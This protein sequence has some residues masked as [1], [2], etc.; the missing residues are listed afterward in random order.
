MPYRKVSAIVRGYCGWFRRVPLKIARPLFCMFSSVIRLPI[1][2][3]ALVSF[4]HSLDVREDSPRKFLF[5]ESLGSPHLQKCG[6][7]ILVA[8]LGSKFPGAHGEEAVPYLTYNVAIP[9]GAGKPTV[10]IQDIADTLLQ[11]ELAAP[12]DCDAAAQPSRIRKAGSFSIRQGAVV[13]RDGIRR[14]A[15]DIPLLR[16]GKSGYVFRSHFRVS[17]QWSPSGLAKS[18]AAPGKRVLAQVDNPRGARSFYRAS[19]ARVLRRSSQELSDGIEWLL[20]I[21]VGDRELAT[22]REDGLYA[23]PYSQM[24]TRLRG[25]PLFDRIDGIRVGSLTVAAGTPDTLR[26]VPQT[27]VP[28]LGPLSE[29]AILVL[30]HGGAGD[31]KPDGI[32]NEGDTLVFFASGT[33]HWKPSGSA[34]MPY[35]FSSNLYSFTRDYY[36]GVRSDN[37]APR[38]AS[39]AQSGG[40]AVSQLT[41]YVRAEKDLLLRDTYFGLVAGGFDE[42]TGKEWFWIWGDTF[43]DSLKVGSSELSLP[44]VKELPGLVAGQ[45]ATLAIAYFPYRSMYASLAGQQ[46]RGTIISALPEY[47]R[48]ERLDF[49]FLVNG[50]STTRTT[51]RLPGGQFVA[52]TN[53]LKSTENQFELHMLPNRRQFDRFDGF[54]VAYKSYVQWFGSQETWLAGGLYGNIRF[55]VKQSPSNLWALRLNGQVPLRL[56]KAESGSFSDSVSVIDDAR[57]HLFQWGN[58]FPLADSAVQPFYPAATGTIADVASLGGNYEYVI[59]CPREWASTAVRLKKFREG[60]DVS[61]SYRTAVVELE[62]IWMQYGSGYASPTAIRD[63]L[64]MARYQWKDLKY[65]LLVGDGHPDYRG[66]RQ[67]SGGLPVIPP[68]EKEDMGTDDYFAVL[69]SGEALLYGDYDLDLAVGRLPVNQLGEFEIYVG[70]V[71]EYE[72]L[73][74]QDL[75]PWRNTLLMAADDAMQKTLLD[76][77]PGHTLQTEAILRDLEDKSM[78]QGYQIDMQRLYLLN[79][80]A[81]MAHEKPNASQ[82]LIARMNQGALFTIY[83]GH[84]SS[85]DWADEGLLKPYMLQDVDN[86]GRYTILGSFACTVGRFDLATM[87]SLSEIFMRA[88]GKGAIASIGAMRESFPSYNQDLA[89]GMLRSAFLEQG[90]TLGNALWSGKGKSFRTSTDYRYNNERYVLLGE[91]VLGLPKTSAD[92][93]LDTPLDTLQALQ[94]V[95][96]SGRVLDGASSGKL[97]I[98]VL[99]GPVNRILE[100][101]RPDTS[102]FTAPVRFQGRSI[103][104]EIVDYKEGKFSVEFLSPRKLSFGDTAAQIR[105]WAWSQGDSRIGRGVQKKVLISGTSPDAGSIVDTVPPDIHFRPCGIPDSLGRDYTAGVTV[106]MEIPACLEVMVDDSIG[107]DLQEQADEGISFEIVGSKD[108]WHPWPF[109]EQT[110]KRVMT[111]VRFNSSWNPGTYPLRVRAQDIM[112]NQATEEIQIELNSSLKQALTGVFNAPNPMGKSGTTFYFRNL[113]ENHTS[114]ISIEIFGI[115]GRLVKVIQNARS[116]VTRWDG[117]DQWGRMLANGLYHYVVTCTVYNDGKARRFKAKQKLVISR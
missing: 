82:D 77:I 68:F 13:E 100:Q 102:P 41:R 30:D 116:G 111:R 22:L 73:S 6:D 54:S 117:R 93:R 79:Y 53:A 48:F 51:E 67:T 110:G 74:K 4:G 112:G 72:S 24:R 81:D 65:V 56:L 34:S 106:R 101:E 14:V 43:D 44:Q 33:S 59:I 21:P 25:T 31:R 114:A 49:R 37:A 1:L 40:Q 27:R 11:G 42:S 17:V 87:S 88:V 28:Q 107:L 9:H 47:Q 96:L 52:T 86:T 26:E 29:Q 75:G 18:G 20:R 15:I 64:R 50:K 80:E 8:A 19:S 70:K 104:S 10:E 60:R 66:I 109:L 32:W 46:D 23:L 12:Q 2:L 97:L 108:P 16:R 35:Y 71:E 58:W 78:D 113:A 115:D 63:F 69:D 38:L 92:V 95:R 3:L 36:V 94:M 62:Q 99:E 85:T 55:T 84:G 90:G 45:Q 57:Y 105:F 5:E 103:H 61:S 7:R 39:V 98:Q 89:T 91:P 83:F 76:P